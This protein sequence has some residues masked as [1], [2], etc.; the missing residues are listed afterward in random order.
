MMEEKMRYCLLFILILT[1]LGIA[2][3]NDYYNAYPGYAP[4]YGPGPY[5]GGSSVVIA[6]GDRPYYRGTGYWAGGV[7]YVWKPGHWRWRHGQQVWV[8]GHYVA[9]GY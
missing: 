8:R 2:G 9:R 5:Y 7:Y 4:N 3:C 1:V 6:V